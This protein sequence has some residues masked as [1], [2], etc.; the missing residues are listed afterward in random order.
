MLFQKLAK[1]SNSHSQSP[2]SGSQ[3]SSGSKRATLEIF[4][5]L[6]QADDMCEKY[7]ATEDEIDHMLDQNLFLEIAESPRQALF[8]QF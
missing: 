6:R 8:K 7:R 1:A 3:Q 2:S 4:S 5:Q